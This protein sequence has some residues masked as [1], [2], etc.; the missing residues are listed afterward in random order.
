MTVKF[1]KKIE[2]KNVKKKINEEPL[3]EWYHEFPKT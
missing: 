2:K 1:Q 3:G